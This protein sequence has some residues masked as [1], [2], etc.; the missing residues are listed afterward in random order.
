MRFSG[1]YKTK[2]NDAVTELVATKI[3]DRS[4][5]MAAID[6][7]INEYMRDTGEV[8]VQQQLERL[9]NAILMEEL[10]DMHPD[11]VT[12]NEYPFLSEWQFELRRDSEYS[13]KLAEETDTDGRDHKVGKRRF[14]TSKENALVDKY[15]RSRNEE[16][17]KQYRK[18]TDTVTYPTY[19]MADVD[20]YLIDKYGEHRLKYS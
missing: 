9:T 17:R 15:A 1:D 10:T 11:K 18:D 19:K 5:R 4:E 13:L 14:R 2:F 12:N 3:P 16:R 6:A 20:A 7:L 8:P